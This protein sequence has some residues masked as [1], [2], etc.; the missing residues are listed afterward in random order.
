MT[1]R[2]SAGGSPAA[3]MNCSAAR[4]RSGIAGCLFGFFPIDIGYHLTIVLIDERHESGQLIDGLLIAGRVFPYAF[5]LGGGV[6][7]RLAAYDGA[8][9]VA[10]AGTL[11]QD[12][13]GVLVVLA[14][15]VGGVEHR[16]RFQVF[17]DDGGFLDQDPH[18]IDGPHV[19]G[20]WLKRDQQGVGHRQRRAQAAG[21]PSAHVDQ[22]VIVFGGELAG[23]R[24]HRGAAQGD[25]GV[26]VQAGLFAP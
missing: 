18:V 22:E 17:V 14:D 26:V 16:K 9:E 8:I 25:G 2:G 3:A 13:R 4:S 6:R 21:I 1:L 23:L 7:E 12:G 20:A 10:D 11:A 15:G 19:E 24:P 5:A